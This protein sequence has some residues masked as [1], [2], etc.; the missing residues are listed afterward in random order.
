MGLSRPVA[1]VLCEVRESID[2]LV[3]VDPTSVADGASV[4]ELLRE[5]SRFEA[6]VCRQAASFDAGG[7]WVDDEAPNSSVWVTTSAR[8]ERRQSRRRLRIGKALR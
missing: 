4:V 2:A 7:A 3:D 1:D 6:V 5:L 8:V